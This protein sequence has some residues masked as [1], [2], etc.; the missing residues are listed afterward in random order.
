MLKK[1]GKKCTK[2]EHLEII[3]D[4]CASYSAFVQMQE[5]GI[6]YF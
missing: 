5:D 6:N 2:I 4:D 3:S 1:R